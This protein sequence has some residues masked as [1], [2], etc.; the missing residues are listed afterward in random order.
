MKLNPHSCYR[1]LNPSSL[2]NGDTPQAS[3][4]CATYTRPDLY[5]NPTIP[6]RVTQC[7]SANEDLYPSRIS[8]VCTC[9]FPAAT[10]PAAIK[11]SKAVPEVKTSTVLQEVKTSSTKIVAPVITSKPVF[12][13]AFTKSVGPIYTT[14]PYGPGCNADNCLRACEYISLCAYSHEQIYS[15]GP[16]TS[17][18]NPL[19]IRQWTVKDN[20][21][22]R[23]I[24]QPSRLA[25]RLNMML[26][27]H[28]QANVLVVAIPLRV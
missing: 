5:P 16:F 12:A 25:S 17:L 4:F 24:V 8:S 1:G 22:K 2:R 13:S 20:M 21:Q 28:T 7:S 14:Q 10:T 18:T 27:Q 19:T 6:A 9:V 26:S 11:T 15:L 23:Q 3:D